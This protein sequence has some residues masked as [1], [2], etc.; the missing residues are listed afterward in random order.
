MI[1]RRSEDGRVRLVADEASLDLLV[2]AGLLADAPVEQLRGVE[3][4]GFE[5]RGRPVRLRVSGAPLIVKTLRHGGLAGRLLGTRFGARSGNVRRLLDAME[6]AQRLLARGVATARPAFARIRGGALPGSL[7]LELATYE[8][9][10]A[11]DAAT[12]LAAQRDAR[13]RRAAIRACGSAVQALH[14]AGVRHADLNLKNLLVVAG[15]EARA[16]VIDLERSTLPQP[17]LPRHRVENLARLLR[18][19]EKLGLLGPLVT[20][21]D[22]VRFLVAYEPGAWRELFAAVARDHAARGP[23]HR[24]AWRVSRLFR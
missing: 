21:R 7:R 18:S 1:E 9:E 3:A 14:E 17:L 8:I 24:L 2:A 13:A 11:R 23:W 15:R 19:T 5:G 4:T 22:L 6:L 10:G 16:Y 20:R 12:F